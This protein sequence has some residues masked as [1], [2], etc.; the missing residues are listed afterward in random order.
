MGGLDSNERIILE[1]AL[2]DIDSFP[3]RNLSQTFDML[4]SLC[5]SERDKEQKTLVFTEL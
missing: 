3:G 2:I 4:I 5:R 1:Q